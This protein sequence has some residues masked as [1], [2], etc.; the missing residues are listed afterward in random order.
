VRILPIAFLLSSL[1]CGTPVND[2]IASAKIKHG[3]AGE[4][5]A[6]FLVEHMPARDKES[7]SAEFLTNNLDLAFKVRAEFPWTKGIPEEIFLNDVLPYAV[8]DETREPWRADFQDRARPLVK[9]AKSASEAVQILNR[10]F[11]KLVNVHYNTGR[12]APNQ[13]ASESM[14]S[15]RATCTGLS[16]I[17]VDACRTVGIPAR[18][19]GTPMWTNGRGNH[20]WVEI[21]DGDWHFL[22]ADEY[23]ANGLNRG[24]FTAD[25]SLA[26]ADDPEHAIYATSWKRDKLAFPMV[27]AAGVR[28]V[29]AVN[30][31][32]RYAKAATDPGVARL[33]IRLFDKKGGER[34][35]AK[36]RVIPGGVS[37]EAE[38]KAGTSDLNDMP[39]FELK[40]GAKGSVFF[41]A[42]GETRELTFGPLDKGEPTVDAVWLDMAKSSPAISALNT[43]LATPADKRNANDPGLQLPMSREDAT[44]ATE[45]LA[46]DRLS[47][48]AAERKDELEKKSITIGDKTMRWLEKSFGEAPIGDRSL[49]ISMHGGGG[50]PTEV[51]DGQWQNQIKLYEPAEGI[52]IAPRAPTDTWNLWHEAHIDPM[53][54][55]L[56]E[57]HIALRGVNPNKVYLLGYSAGGDGVWQLAPRMADRF[58]AAAMMAGHPNEASLLGL[59]NLPFAIFMGGKDAAYNR[60]KIAAGKIQELNQLEQADPGGYVHMSRI[61]EG[62]GHWMKRKDAEALPWMAGFIRNPWPKKIVWMQDDIVHDRFYWLKI[63]DLKAAM[64]GQKL[65]ATVDGQTIRLEGDVPPKTELWL[66]DKLLDL[67]QTITVIVNDKPSLTF[68][69]PRTADVIRRSL[70]E[71]IDV[72]AAATVVVVVP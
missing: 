19:V 46:S 35:V 27:W 20:T 52:Y 32:A 39:R 3:E 30:V 38:T 16:I 31:T 49:W 13:S 57:D 37:T 65:V 12:K 24:W 5:A 10:E 56:I 61:Y 72:P 9:D 58:A 22:G 23:D 55:R 2:F 45:L 68:N 54:Q 28:D 44:M 66:S 8:F 15:G 18:A 25:A 1:A 51:N 60:N 36:I 7:L 62:F 50:A 43:W 26:Q 67:G 4:K 42:K 33:G 47:L 69:P 17:L 40:P 48:L 70:E 6:R 29:G 21:W 71:R 64:A 14:A 34:M 41:T 11:F 63:P 53:F 59:R